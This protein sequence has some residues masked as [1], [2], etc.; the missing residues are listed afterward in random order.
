MV[1]KQT[2]IPLLF[3]AKNDDEIR[4]ILS[5]YN[6]GCLVLSHEHKVLPDKLFK[7]NDPWI[8]YKTSRIKVLDTK[9]NNFLI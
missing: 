4:Y 6:I 9:E 2:L 3:K 8:R 7:I 1:E 5:T